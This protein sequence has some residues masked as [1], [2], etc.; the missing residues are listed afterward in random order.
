MPALDQVGGPQVRGTEGGQLRREGGRPGD[1]S[2]ARG[3]HARDLLEPGR[4]RG[5]PRRSV[6]QDA[7]VQHAKDQG[8]AGRKDVDEAPVEL[9][10]RSAHK[11][12]GEPA[13]HVH[14][15]ERPHRTAQALARNEVRRRRNQNWCGEGVRSTL[16]ETAEKEPL[17]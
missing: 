1:D 14:A 3:E 2:A 13:D 8:N 9:C 17:D 6:A 10:E 4:R 11:R 15:D 5:V 7:V 16:E 12:R